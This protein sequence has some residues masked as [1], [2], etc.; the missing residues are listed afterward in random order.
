MDSHLMMMQAKKDH[1]IL[2]QSLANFHEQ[3]LNTWYF[4]LNSGGLFASLTLLTINNKDYKFLCF[5][6]I[7]I[8]T[9][10][11]L[12]IILSCIFQKK[13]L[14]NSFHDKT[15]T[16]FFLKDRAIDLFQ[17]SSVILF[18]SGVLVGLTALF[19]DI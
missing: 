13:S 15:I 16:S 19:L 10:G 3:Q 17:W 2:L 7:I 8:F 6:L 4:T 5:V 18:L 1:K 9:L 11:L 14:Q 12:S